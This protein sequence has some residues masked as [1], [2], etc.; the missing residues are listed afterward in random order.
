M[1][2]SQGHR[3]RGRRRSPSPLTATARAASDDK[4]D[5]GSSG[6]GRKINVGIKNDQPVLGLKTPTAT[7]SGFDIDVADYVAKELGYK[8]DQIEFVETKSA[9]RETAHLHAA[10]SKFIA[11]T[12]SINDERKKKVDFAG[13]YFLA[14]QD[15]LVRA[16]DED[17][18]R[19]RR[20]QRQEA[21][22]GHRLD[23][24]QNVKKT[25]RR[26]RPAAAVQRLL[27]VHA[28]L[29]DGAVDAVTTDD[30]ILAGY[31]AQDKYKGKFKLV[32]SS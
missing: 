9:D 4:D 17:A 21:L 5:S 30:S 23:S 8:P 14:R 20:P 2:L 28:G 1:K 32:G 16:D 22:L 15:L 6:G 31:A 12:Y 10:T 26:P 3:R 19:R 29:P 24:A 25:S 18:S 13:P 7:F 27:R 11:A